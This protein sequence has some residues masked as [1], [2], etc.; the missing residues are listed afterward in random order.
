MR[1]IAL[2]WQLYER[3]RSPW[4]LGLIGLVQ[5]VPVAVLS[6]P[7][8]A[9][10]D[11]HLRRK[12]GALTQ[13]GQVLVGIGMTFVSF[14][15][16]PVPVFYALLFIS[17]VASAFGGPAI[18]SLLP[19]LVP[20]E[21]LSR[22]N[23][24][25]SSSWQL[26][27]MVGPGAAG[28]LLA[29]IGDA[30]PLYFLDAL[31]AAIFGIVL[32]RLPT[33]DTPKRLPRGPV[34][35]RAGLRFVFR[36]KELRGAIMLD[37]FA[38][39]LGGTTAL[40]PIFAKDILR[41]GPSGLGWLLAAPSVGA[42]LTTLVQTRLPIWRRPGWVLLISVAGFGAAT[43]GFGLS[44]SF[45]LSLGLLFLTGAFDSL[46]VVIRRTL[47]QV[48]APDRIRGRVAAVHQVFLGISDELGEF[49]SGATAALLG[50]IGSV[51]LGGLG[52]LAVV[53]VAAIAL[54]SLRRMGQLDEMRPREDLDGG[55][56][57]G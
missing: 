57:L 10:A 4:A 26:A 29:S 50:A 15:K 36:C 40:M 11:R 13:L 28:L 30:T 25:F 7:A 42:T 3:T 14:T 51:L 37:L 1:S 54:P 44:R 23:A 16:A 48:L 2:A 38:V 27:S 45:P 32:W 43:L 41:V 9:I 20:A 31:S 39:L 22:A 49:E 12:I 34:D 55:T 52:T 21:R 24:W 18:T 46:S 56:A 33:R 6:L 17:G 19:E 5:V 35:L 8:G 47:E 53:L